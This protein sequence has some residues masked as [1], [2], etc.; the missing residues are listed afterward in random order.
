M[1]FDITQRELMVRA[2][3][4]LRGVFVLGLVVLIASLGSAIEPA[5]A[6]DASKADAELDE[7]DAQLLEDL[8][9]ALSDEL[10]EDLPLPF[11]ADDPTSGES[12][13]PTKPEVDD[14]LADGLEGQQE[15]IVE[16]HPLSQ[17]GSEMQRVESLIAQQQAGDQTRQ[18]QKQIVAQ[19][20]K[21]IEQALQQAQQ[22]SSQQQNS[23]QQTSQ[24][25]KVRQPQQQPGGNNQP[26]NEPVRDSQERV[27]QAKPEKDRRQEV[28]KMMEELWGHLPERIRQQVIN[29]SMEEFLP[30]YE[31]EI[32]QYFRRLAEEFNDA[33]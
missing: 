16:N 14:P 18:L 30:A 1:Y 8:D 15:M 11:D 28:R 10:M 13:R 31:L 25:D 27:G 29:A 2:S 24:R 32:E 19:L 3:P 17:I 4:D 5:V 20:D 23:Q 26:S 22:S 21:L 12:S 33:R 6:Q 7:L 9:D